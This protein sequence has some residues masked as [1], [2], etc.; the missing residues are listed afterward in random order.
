MRKNQ[1]NDELSVAMLSCI[2][3]GVVSTDLN[4]I[5]IYYNPK[6]AEILECKSEQ[7]IGTVFNELF[8]LYHAITGK[9]LESPV[10]NVLNTELTTGLPDHSIIKVKG[11][12]KY[13]SATCSPIRAV[14]GNMIGSMIVMRDITKI[15]TL[16]MAYKE[17]VKNFLA[18]MSHE[19][20]T[21]INGIVGM[22]D[23][24]L[25]SDLTEIQKDNLRTAKSCAQALMNIANDILDFSK[26]E[27]GKMSLETINFN[28]KELIEEVI[29]VH[30]PR[31]NNKGVELNYIFSSTIPAYVHGDPNRLRQILNNLLSNA[32]KFTEIGEVNL[33]VTN[34]SKTNEEEVL[35]FAVS[36]TGI[37]IKSGD[38]S[39][40]FDSF[41]Q[42]ENTYTKQYGGTGLGL[43][44][45]K[46]LV[47]MMGGEIKVESERGKGSTFYF[48]LAF[49]PGKYTPASY[50]PPHKVKR[51][52]KPL[53]ILL[54][55]DDMINQKIVYTML[56]EMGHYI[57]TASNGYAALEFITKENYDAILMDIQMPRMN[58]V[59]ATQR[60]RQLNSYKRNI[61]IIAMTA[62][63]LAGDEEKFLDLGLNS[64]ISKPVHMEELFNVLEQIMEK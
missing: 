40:L 53:H 24:T 21:P 50:K 2:G 18:N 22:I 20:R 9:Q 41:S 45:T 30:S 59:E 15:L 35:R 60:I 32:I 12:Q 23:L 25:R 51:A 19:I 55:D 61:P 39:K 56:S 37:G 44:I 13:I 42:L 27:A 33:L 8:V 36:D 26:M 43:V 6:A 5:I 46:Q 28:L 31:A 34:I 4:G 11:K 64:Y 7:A 38:I 49:Q 63:A 62:Y 17:E 16:E 10:D 3:D 47:E 58:G 48:V 29:R 1:V 57:Q 14:E 52:D 54:V